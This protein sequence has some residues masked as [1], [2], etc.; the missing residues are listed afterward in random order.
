MVTKFG[1]ARRSPLEIFES[2][3]N[4]A[5]RSGRS[6]NAERR[7]EG[8]NWNA[9]KSVKGMSAIAWRPWSDVKARNR[10]QAFEAFKPISPVTAPMTA[11]PPSGQ[12][13]LECAYLLAENQQELLWK[14]RC[15]ARMIALN[16]TTLP[17]SW[18]RAKRVCAI[19]QRATQGRIRWREDC[20]PLWRS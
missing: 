7:L 16:S 1:I 20:S 6:S 12:L 9:A 15:A 5:R 2:R 18:R 11:P 14:D 10:P 3:D 8:R 17:W 4:S 13:A 19:L